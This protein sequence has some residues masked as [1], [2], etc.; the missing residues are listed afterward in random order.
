MINSRFIAYKILEA[1][2]LKNQ[3]TNLAL[4]NLQ[5][6]PQD[7][8]FITKLV[9]TSLQNYE[10][11]LFQS[12]EYLT[13]PVSKQA[14]ILL[15][16]GNCQHYKMDSIQD[17]AI[18]NEMVNLA[19]RVAP[20]YQGLIN[21]VLK[22][23]FTKPYRLSQTENEIMNLSIN[24]STPQ[25]IASLL[26]S[27]YGQDIAEKI[28][29]HNQT[30]APLYVRVNPLKATETEIID[31]YPVIK[32]GD[33][34]VGQQSLLK[35]DALSLG[36]AV[37]QDKTSQKICTLFDLTGSKR[38]LDACSAPGTKTSQLATMVSQGEIVAVE[39]HEHRSK[40]VIDLMKRLSINNVTTITSDILEITFDQQFDAI[41]C[42]VPCSGLGV[43]RRKPDLKY[44]LS[45]NDLDTL[46]DLQK[47]ILNHV[48]S[49]LKVNGQ[50]VYS[51]C[52]LNRKENEKQIA[53][54]LKENQNYRLIHEETVLGYRENS[55]GFYMAKLIKV[56]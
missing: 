17:Y 7:T 19:K 11:L 24:T 14:E 42:D 5:T 31:N 9:Y 18:V 37:I 50:L 12:S 6:N 38:V 39:L 49:F 55:D 8:R 54:F 44:R 10:S 13:K 56:A 1:T 40:L 28:L 2:L 53:S 36:L 22:K 30:E 29:A 27:Q 45:Q 15:V 41:L 20:G 35:S 23:T 33:Y 16:M 3:Y 51:T 25:W 21:A 47:K 48:S 52:T 32:V 26:V 43:L 4:K 46:Q 34:F